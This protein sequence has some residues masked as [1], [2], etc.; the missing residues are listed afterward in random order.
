MSK[1]LVIAE[2]PSVAGDLARALGGFT[3]LDDYFERDDMLVSSAIGH[4]VELCLPGEL[5]KQRGKW[6]LANLPIIPEQFDLK[7]IERTKARFNLLKRLMR[8][9][10]VSALINA[11]DAG[12]EGELIFRYLVQHSGVKKPIQRLWLQ[13]M[14]ADSIRKAFEKL[15]SDEE[16]QPLADAAICR[17]E[18]DW[19]VGINGTRAMTH[20]NSQGAGFQLTPVGRVQTPTLAIL[21]EREDKI[22][23]FVPRPY[24][25][26]HATFAIK[27]GDYQ[28]R[29]FDERFQKTEDEHR[30]AER[31]W[32]RSQAEDIVEACQGHP[33][34]I[35]EERKPGTQAS[36]L[37]YDLTSLQRDANGRFGFSAGRTLQ[38][39]QRLY[40]RHKAL[41]YP[42]T[43][44][45]CL[46]EDYIGEVKSICKALQ[47]TELGSFAKK[48]LDQDWVKPNKR[49]FNNAKVSD[50]F[51]IIPTGTI[52]KALDEAEQKLFLLVARRFLAIF[53]P[54]ARFEVTSRITR[55][56]QH[57]FKSEGKIITDPGWMAVY[58]REASSDDDRVL[59]AYQQGEAADT[60]EVKV[61][62][63]LTRPP[64]RFNESTLL[65][66]MEGAGKFV[67]DEHLR[68]AM[69]TRGLGTP[70]TRA[71][72]IEGLLG[73][74]YVLRQ[75][76]D[77]IATP[78]GIS[79]INLLRSIGVEALTRPELT[80]EWE[81]KLKEM[82][83]GQMPREKFMNE[84][85]RLTQEIV[86]KTRSFGEGEVAGDYEDL[87][88]KCPRCGTATFREDYRA[89]T[90]RSCDY[91]V[92]KILASREFARDEVKELLEKG[93]TRPLQGFRNRFGRLFEG[94]V[95]LNE[96]FKP[97]FDFGNEG[98]DQE[99]KLEEATATHPC[100]A[101]VDGKLYE[102]DSFFF[103]KKPDGEKELALKINKTILQRTIPLEQAMKIVNE[104]RTDL[105]PQFI[106]KKGRPFKAYLVLTEGAIKFE[107]E[108]RKPKDEKG[109]SKS[110]TKKP[111]SA[112]K[113]KVS[114]T[115]KRVVKKGQSA[116]AKKAAARKKA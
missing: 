72:I 89:F 61:H 49:I 82:E 108:E 88:V 1:T 10:D 23:S 87:Q 112:T 78:K 26:V 102:F 62:E 19:L 63:D 6:N 37:L 94:V 92:W 32:E 76:R 95:K 25:E 41:S 18:S 110:T 93:E 52:P 28:G 24:F 3:R 36:P 98:G 113:K 65:S 104:G 48:V 11:C 56:N 68:E 31:L 81:S 29:W 114:T 15:R 53:Y 74:G 22:R 97:T 85:R 51:A 67:E 73:D 111:V 101:A 8:R 46:P 35:E 90:C 107:F 116:T 20:F 4:L 105:L 79:L 86:E 45:K 30:K 66:A 83:Q 33:G 57:P 42:R 77:L 21:A 38:L 71:A 55:V 100:E 40:E 69:G 103:A 54:P 84:I 34:I 109:A 60:Q 27:E 50:H 17:S 106:S 59:P 9:E 91:R 2:K 47:P 58:G 7:P 75:N 39:A 5:D 44:S 99:I 70:A 64:A 80:G 13:S 115:P 16:L 12:R 14:T 96:E 43:D